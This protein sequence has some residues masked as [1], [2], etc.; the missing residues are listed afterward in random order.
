M[1]FREAKSSKIV[2]LGGI[3]IQVDKNHNTLNTYKL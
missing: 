1:Y 2:K 3:I